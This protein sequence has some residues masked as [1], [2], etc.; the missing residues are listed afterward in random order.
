[1]KTTLI[2]RIYRTLQAMDNCSK[3]NKPGWCKN[4]SYYL[5]ELEKNYLPRGSGIDSGCTID[6]AF[7]ENKIVINV[8]FHLMCE[9]GYYCGWQDFK[10]ICKPEFDGI[11]MKITS[12]AKDKFFLKDYLYD[13][14]DNCLTKQIEFNTN[15]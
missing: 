3:N 8:P 15:N 5:D 10:I 11:S 2:S 7:K 1:M 12:N 6:R 13:L 14:F 4:H 9:N